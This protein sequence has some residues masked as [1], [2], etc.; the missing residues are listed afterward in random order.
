MNYELNSSINSIREKTLSEKAR[1]HADTLASFANQR[2]RVQF[3]TK[4]GDGELRTMICIPRNDYNRVMAIPTT[5]RG[6]KMV[7]SKAKRNMATVCEVVG[8]TLRPRTIN[9]MTIVD[10]IERV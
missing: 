5:V 2:V 4:N 1:H 10:E 7:A 9:L 3:V 6:R 8:D